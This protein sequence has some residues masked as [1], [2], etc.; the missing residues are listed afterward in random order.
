M[1]NPIFKH[2]SFWRIATP[3]RLDLLRLTR[4]VNPESRIKM[5]EINLLPKH[6]LDRGNS[7]D[8]IVLIDD[9]PGRAV[10]RDQIRCKGICEVF[11]TYTRTTQGV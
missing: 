4:R 7:G 3:L 1:R 8:R 2:I 5:D 6:A 10:W 11:E 9:S